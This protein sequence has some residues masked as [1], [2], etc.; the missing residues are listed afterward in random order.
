M[1]R[2]ARVRILAVTA[3]CA[4]AL[5][6]AACGDDDDETTETEATGTVEETDD[7]SELRSAFNEQVRQ[8]LLDVQGLSEAQADCA[9]DELG[10]SISDA[11]IEEANESGEPSQDILDAAIDAGQECADAG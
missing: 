6:V 2:I 7:V 9:I 5:G 4:A 10:T 1:S 8:V 11:D 3:I